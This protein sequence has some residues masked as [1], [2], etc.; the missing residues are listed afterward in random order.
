MP[1][2]NK[3]EEIAAIF[4]SRILSGELKPGQDFPTNEQIKQEFDV[5]F[6]TV[7]KAVNILI[8]EGLVTHGA[9]NM[10][11]KV[12]DAV[13]TRSVRS[14]GFLQ[15]YQDRGNQQL[16]DLRIHTPASGKKLPERV[17]QVLPFPLLRYK[18]LQLRDGIP[19]AISDAFIP[20]VVPLIELLDK[21]ALPDA[22]LYTVLKGFGVSVS[23]CRESLFFDW[24]TT[25]ECALFGIPAGSS[26]AVVRIERRVFDDKGNLVEL[27]FLT[28]RADAYEFVYEFELQSVS[29]SLPEGN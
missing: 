24:A 7:H 8:A 21:L 23:R 14:M 6:N 28:D 17:Q 20:Q 11:R 2:K 22:E 4:K 19:V 12:R 1:R 27:C 25:E 10:R 3:A 26:L 5:A 16:L 13:L 18:T 15:E 29:H 9:G